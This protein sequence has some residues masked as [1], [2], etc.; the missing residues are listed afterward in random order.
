MKRII[1]FLALLLMIFS[2]KKENKITDSELVSIS[3]IDT[4]YHDSISIRALTI[5]DSEVWFAI[6]LNYQIQGKGYGRILLEEI[7]KN[8]QRKASKI[9]KHIADIHTVR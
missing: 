4:L 2:C 3:K 8:I 9:R 7:K 6:M 1:P 5:K